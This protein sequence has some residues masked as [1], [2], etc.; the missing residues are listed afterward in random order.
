MLD[1]CSGN[2]IYLVADHAFPVYRDADTNVY[3]DADTEEMLTNCCPG[4]LFTNLVTDRCFEHD[5][6]LIDL[7]T[8]MTV[9]VNEWARQRRENRFQKEYVHEERPWR[10]LPQDNLFPPRFLRNFGCFGVE[11]MEFATGYGNPAPIIDVNVLYTEKT[12]K[13]MEENV[14]CWDC[15]I[16]GHYQ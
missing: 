9:S 12:V 6:R 5:A 8:I 3:R 10:L 15:H 4:I 16:Q 2:W 11:A 7:Q 13:A 14:R 1:H